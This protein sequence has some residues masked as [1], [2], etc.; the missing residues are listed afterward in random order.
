MTDSSV[1]DRVAASIDIAA[2]PEV[3]WALVT[4]VT[5]MPEFSPELRGARWEST[6]TEPKVGARFKGFNKHGAVRWSTSC[7]VIAAEP[8]RRFGYRVTYF[9]LKISEWFFE[10]A[11]AAGGG[12]TLTESTRD[13]RA[14]LT[15]YTTGPATGVLDRATHNLAGIRSTLAAIKTVAERDAA[16]A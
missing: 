6:V 14:I 11:P 3:V 1:H 8:L 13:R 5:R 7:E 4:D 12:T 16:T 2:P 15:K 10:L 9:G